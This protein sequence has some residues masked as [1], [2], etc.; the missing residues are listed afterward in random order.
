MKMIDSIYLNKLAAEQE[1]YRQVL[2]LASLFGAGASLPAAYLVARHWPW[3][4]TLNPL[5]DVKDIMKDWMRHRTQLKLLEQR[6]NKL[7]AAADK[8]YKQRAMEFANI[9]GFY[10]MPL[11]LSPYGKGSFVFFS[12]EN[13]PKYKRARER[14]M[15]AR[16][17]LEGS[18][19]EVELMKFHRDLAEL[20]RTAVK[21]HLMAR[22]LKALAVMGLLGAGGALGY[23]GYRL[24][25][26]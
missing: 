6:Y 3:Q 19:P 10:K 23:A 1:K 2:G 16:R 12:V 26:Q 20:A 15:R 18:I 5:R 8:V 24:L 11:R 4:V 21:E 7:R 13:Y 17:I 22:G 14:Y 25:N 9:K